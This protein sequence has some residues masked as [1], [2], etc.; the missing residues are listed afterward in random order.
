MK[1]LEGSIVEVALAYVKKT[2]EHLTVTAWDILMSNRWINLFPL[3]IIL[4]FL[5]QVSKHIDRKL[6]G[7]LLRREY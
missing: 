5:G 3:A 2:N 4:L 6:N 1:G 7:F